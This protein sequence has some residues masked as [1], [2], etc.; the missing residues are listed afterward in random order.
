MKYT[1]GLLTY[2][3]CIILENF[4]YNNKSKITTM[5]CYSQTKCKIHVYVMLKCMWNKKWSIQTNITLFNFSNL[6]SVTL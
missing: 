5:V 3:G 6:I 4:V 1:N 2:N